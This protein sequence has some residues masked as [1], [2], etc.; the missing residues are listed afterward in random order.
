MYTDDNDIKRLSILEDVRIDNNLPKYKTVN[1]EKRKTDESGD[2]LET[3]FVTTRDSMISKLTYETLSKHLSDK[4]FSIESFNAMIPYNDAPQRWYGQTLSI[5]TSGL[6]ESED[7]MGFLSRM[8]SMFRRKKKKSTVD[9]KFNIIEFFSD[10][11]ACIDDENIGR[12]T[13]RVKELLEYIAYADSIGQKALKEKLIN[14]IIINKYES[15]LYAA[16]MYKAVTEEAVIN[17]ADKAP[18]PVSIDYIENYVRNI[19]ISVAN[20][21]QKADRLMVFDNYCVLHYDPNGTNTKLTKEQEAAKRDPILFGL[22]HGS[23]KLYFVADWV[24]EYCDLTFDEMT[25]I[26]GS[27]LIETGYIREK[28][29][30]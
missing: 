29:Q 27:D 14:E 2:A 3:P 8:V 30:K 26:I 6:S 11:H 13:D 7:K 15:I 17:L 22:I 20:E 16:G 10:I 5:N 25:K 23:K 21:K 1:P 28:I 18:K 4:G 24:D 12:Y 19:P 9:K